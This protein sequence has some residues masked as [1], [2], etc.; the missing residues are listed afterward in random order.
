[1]NII[2][3]NINWYLKHWMEVECSVISDYGKNVGLK[4][5]YVRVSQ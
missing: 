5:F 1:M 2:N 4:L 3:A